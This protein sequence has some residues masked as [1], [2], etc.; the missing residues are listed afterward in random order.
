MRPFEFHRPTSLDEALALLARPDARALAGGTTLVDLMKLG[1]E[2]PGLVVD[3]GRL[4][5]A[6]ITLE[7]GS[8]RI[9][10]LARNSAVARDSVVL[11]QFPALSEALLSGASGQ[12]RNAASMGGNLMQRTRCAYFRSHDWPCNKRVPGSGCPAREGANAHHAVLG[13]SDHCIAVSPS[14]V[15]VALLAL[16][17][18]VAIAGPRG[19]RHVAIADFYRL[20]GDTPVIETV[21]QPGELIVHLDVPATALATRSGY[22]KLRGRASYEFA[23][24]SVAAAVKLEGGVVAEVAVAIGG[25]G[26]V[27]WR[28]RGAERLLIGEAL[29]DAAVDRFCD[30]LLAPARPTPDNRY[31]LD[32]ARGAVHHMLARSRP[33]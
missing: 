22:L 14:D 15:A 5:L 20:P 1:V 2:A 8:L 18:S 32:L 3:I 31:K 4:P 6:G 10:A 30:A 19:V 27:P 28:D 21:V 13:T 25:L 24:A 12:I 23:S 16:D 11:S 9:G 29:G 33:C 7:S 26:T 17:A